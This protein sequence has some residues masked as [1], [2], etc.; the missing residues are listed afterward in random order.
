MWMLTVYVLRFTFSFIAKVYKRPNHRIIRHRC[1][2]DRAMRTC[3]RSPI[4]ASLIVVCGPISQ[5]LPTRVAPWSNV[6]GSSTVFDA[7]G[8][9]NVYIGR[10]R[11]DDRTPARI[12]ASSS[13]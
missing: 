5:P 1:P 8:Y 6:P 10:R 11:V 2:L 9:A 4:V 7:D 12:S 13:R 3:A